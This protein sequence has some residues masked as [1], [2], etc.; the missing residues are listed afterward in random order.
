MTE[1]QFKNIKQWD[2]LYID[3]IERISVEWTRED[4][5]MVFYLDFYEF[6]HSVHYSRLE[7]D[8]TDIEKDLDKLAEKATKNM[9]WD[10]KF[11][12]MFEDGFKQGFREAMKYKGKDM[13][14]EEQIKKY[15][16]EQKEKYPD[17]LYNLYDAGYTDAINEILEY[18]FGQEPE[19]EE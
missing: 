19:K 18:F 16:Q 6:L 14:T 11:A 13:I 3:G 15:L 8:K 2:H 7:F 17:A 4:D 10:K 9:W 5:G 12:D 1:E